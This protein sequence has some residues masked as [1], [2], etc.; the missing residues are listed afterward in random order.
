MNED[1][2]KHPRCNVVEGRCLKLLREKHKITGKSWAEHTKRNKSKKR[3]REEG[4]GEQDHEE[5]DEVVAE[6]E[7][8]SDNDKQNDIFVTAGELLLHCDHG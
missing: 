2:R 4:P 8:I 6:M 7:M 5:M 1:A 3:T